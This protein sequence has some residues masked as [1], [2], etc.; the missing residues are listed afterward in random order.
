MPT[1]REKIK[2]LK[3]SREYLGASC[4]GYIRL[5]P[6]YS[7]KLFEK[8][9]DRDSTY[10]RQ[11]IA[12]QYGFGP[13]ILFKI[14]KS[15]MFGYITEHAETEKPLTK[16]QYKWLK[17]KIEMI[18]WSHEDTDVNVNVGL[19]NGKPKLIDYDNCSLGVY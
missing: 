13:K 12:N 2:K 16:K 8:E 10:V 7:L 1:L 15:K 17:D 5:T 11:S 4:N 18:G 3:I 19:I 6:K 9:F 14:N